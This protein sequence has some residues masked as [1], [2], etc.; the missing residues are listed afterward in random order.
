ML[1][2]QNYPFHIC[3]YIYTDWFNV[4]WISGTR[5]TNPAILQCNAWS[6][7]TNWYQTCRAQHLFTGINYQNIIYNYPC[8]PVNSILYGFHK[9]QIMFLFW[10]CVWRSNNLC[11][12]YDLGSQ[13][14]KKKMP[15]F[16]SCINK[17]KVKLNIYSGWTGCYPWIAQIEI[18]L[19]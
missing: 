15:N 3:T 4:C 8:P 18:R 11:W 5:T 9:S 7:P 17:Y 19:F 2:Y 14:I 13:H 12:H 10:W 6:T 1:R 16:V